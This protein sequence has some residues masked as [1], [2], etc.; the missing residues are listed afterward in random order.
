MAIP[1]VVPV[2]AC[3]SSNSGL[4][5]IQADGITDTACAG[6]LWGADE[7]A[8]A[9]VDSRTYEVLFEGADGTKH[10]L[11]RVRNLRITDLPSDTPACS[12]SH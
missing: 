9:S 12:K 8:P 3:G 11:K 10:Q 7:T 6:A 2:S 5:L 1:G 4:K